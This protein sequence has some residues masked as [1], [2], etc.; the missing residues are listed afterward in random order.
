MEEQVKLKQIILEVCSIP[1]EV[2]GGQVEVR[3]IEVP[4]LGGRNVEVGDG[5]VETGDV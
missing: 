1:C 5:R 3:R 4:V 2:E